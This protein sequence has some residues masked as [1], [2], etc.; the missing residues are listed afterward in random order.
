MKTHGKEWTRNGK[1]EWETMNQLM[2]TDGSSPQVA[3]AT[4]LG[5]I[6]FGLH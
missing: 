3:M 1:I 2:W 6:T 5:S 4:W